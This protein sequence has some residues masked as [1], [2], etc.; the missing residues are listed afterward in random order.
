MTDTAPKNGFIDNTT[1]EKYR[2]SAEPASLTTSLAKERGNIR[3]T[4]MLENISENSTPVDIL[5]I[6]ATG[7]DVNTEATTF[8]FT[9]VY[10]R[11]NSVY[12]RNEL[13]SNAIITGIAALKRQV[14]RTFAQSIV[15]NTVVYDP[16]L[17]YPPDG[18]VAFGQSVKIVTAEA[19]L[20]DL[21]TIEGNITV[22]QI[23]NT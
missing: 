16:T 23:T 20:T 17:V 5:N 13:S 3:Y 11:V 15:K 21:T 7:A 8:A 10:D 19:P 2:A 14:A 12:T 9:V 22:S 18:G 6:V 1:V 4:K